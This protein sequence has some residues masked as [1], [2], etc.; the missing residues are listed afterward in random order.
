MGFRVI[1]IDQL[2]AGQ[3]LAMPARPPEAKRVRPDPVHSAVSAQAGR[4]PGTERGARA[5]M[6]FCAAAPARG[7]AVT[8][9]SR[10]IV[11]RSC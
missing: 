6:A 1:E 9:S 4:D 8:D 10:P 3:D 2:L 11:D 7:A 5:Q